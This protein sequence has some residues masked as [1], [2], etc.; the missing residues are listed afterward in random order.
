MDR[1][2][3]CNMSRAFC[4]AAAN[5]RI[6]GVSIMLITGL[7]S[8][9]LLGPCCSYHGLFNE[10]VPKFHVA[11]HASHAALQILTFKNFSP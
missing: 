6:I 4:D 10:L 3:V 8:G 2:T 5:A 9:V 1:V 11:L 7:E